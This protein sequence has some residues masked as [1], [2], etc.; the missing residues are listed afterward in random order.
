MLGRRTYAAIVGGELA[1]SVG[2]LAWDVARFDWLRSYDAYANWLDAETVVD[3]HRLP[4][5]EESGVWHSPPLWFLLAGLVGRAA[6]TV[7]IAPQLAGQLLSV[8]A[9]LALLILVLFLA[10]AIWPDRHVLHLVALGFAGAS[11]VLVRASVM[12]HPETLAA[13][14]ATTGVLI[15][16]RTLRS[17][18]T[19]LAGACSGLALGLGVLTRAWV[20]PV[21]VAVVAVL[22]VGR[23]RSRAWAPAALCVAALIA[24]TA[25]WFVNQQVAHGNALAFNR[26]SPE[27]SL[28][29]RRPASFWLGPRALE[30]FD[31]PHAPHARN[32]LAPQLYADWW[33]DYWLVWGDE[34]GDAV[35]PGR[36]RQSG[37]G[38][39]PTTLGL[40]G[41]VALVLLAVAR[42]DAALALVPATALA[43]A[44]AFV[45]F[46]LRYPSTDGDTIKATYL[47]LAL[48]ALA[49]GAAFAADVLSRR[50][51]AAGI[52]LA[53]AAAVL[54]ASEIEFLLL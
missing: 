3:N 35:E 42:R 38:L 43:L 16:V 23:V 33:G 50:S 2:V 26:A 24:V 34:T 25:P 18:P 46:Q 21:A 19:L 20:L 6:G 44:A 27:G 9:G 10:R 8:T 13:A 1:L 32:Q 49:L 12:Y 29:T 5:T 37:L 17:E 11:P 45:L 30:M 47:L 51:R 28:V 39:L 14:L 7:G 54:I 22:A 15:A 41:I 31:T 4:S 52:A 40:G 36:V 48:P 53:T